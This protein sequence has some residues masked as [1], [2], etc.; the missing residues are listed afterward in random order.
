MVGSLARGQFLYWRAA[1]D[2]GVWICSAAVNSL[3]TALL[4][5]AHN[6]VSLE[7]VIFDLEIGN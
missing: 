4:Q 1:D 7:M 3:K 5:V 6:A 2:L